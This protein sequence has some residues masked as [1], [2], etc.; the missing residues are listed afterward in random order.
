MFGARRTADYVRRPVYGRAD[1]EQ[2]GQDGGLPYAGLDTRGV[3]GY[4]AI[5]VV[6]RRHFT[7]LIQSDPL[8]ARGL[9]RGCCLRV[10][11]ASFTGGSRAAFGAGNR[12]KMLRRI[13]Y[14]CW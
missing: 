8:L 6:N 2:A 4:L 11:R 7:R 13:V 10:S 9:C 3:V 5:E 1:G 12:S 14:G